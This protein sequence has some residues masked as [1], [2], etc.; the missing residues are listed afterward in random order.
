MGWASAGAIFERVADDLIA[1]GA[2]DRT[3]RQVCSSLIDVLCDR[4]WDTAEESMSLYEDDTAIISAFEDNKFYF[5]CHLEAEVDDEL[6][7]CE[8]RRDHD[9]PHRDHGGKTWT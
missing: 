7:M 3:R 1:S 2:P 5:T 4:G 6:L 8:E 9:S